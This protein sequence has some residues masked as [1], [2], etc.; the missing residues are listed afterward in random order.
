MS[1]Q[2][3]IIQE[4]ANLYLAW[5]AAFK[6]DSKN[7]RKEFN[8]LKRAAVKVGVPKATLGSVWLEQSVVRDDRGIVQHDESTGCELYEYE[9]MV[10]HDDYEDLCFFGAYDPSQDERD[11]KR[12]TLAK[13]FFCQGVFEYSDAQGIASPSGFGPYGYSQGCVKELAEKHA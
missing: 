9:A 6:A 10:D 7:D 2:N 1:N 8:A 4:L 12:A 3:Q 5:D 13:F 11:V